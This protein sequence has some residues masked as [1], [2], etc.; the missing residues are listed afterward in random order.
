MRMDVVL[1]VGMSLPARIWSNVDLP[2]PLGPTTAR[3]SWGF[4]TMLTF[5]RTWRVLVGGGCSRD[6]GGLDSNSSLLH[7]LKGWDVGFG[8]GMV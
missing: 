7:I 6:D 8:V 1:V 2:A 5:L 4:A 3:I